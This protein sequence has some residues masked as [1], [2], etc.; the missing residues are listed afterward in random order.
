MRIRHQIPLPSRARGRGRRLGAGVASVT[1]LALGLAACGGGSPATT[2]TPGSSAGTGSTATTQA[3]AS[4]TAVAKPVIIWQPGDEQPFYYANGH[5]LWSR[6]HLQPKEVEVSQGTAELS[7]M[8][9]G[10]A[11]I[12][13]LGPAPFVAG[14]SHGIAMVAV[15]PNV[16]FPTLEGLYVAPNSGITGLRSLPGHSVAVPFGSS[17]DTGL[18]FGLA[19]QGV[20]TARIQFQ[21]DSPNAILAGF[22]RHSIDAAYIWSTWGQRLLGAGARLVSTDA[23]EGVDAGPT[24]LAVRTA[25]LSAH[26]KA[27]AEVIATLDEGSVGTR[28]NPA[29][30][31]GALA[32]ATGDTYQ[33]ALTIAKKEKSLTIADALSPSG[34]DSFVNHST[35][36]AAILAHIALQLKGEGLI[37]TVPKNIG[38][39]VVT[40]PLKAGAKLVAA[41]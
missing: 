30:V 27:V 17:A 8:A 22:V 31:A 24:L 7:A 10:S 20:P 18:R 39:F 5:N 21:N 16:D 9:S 36:V 35:G 6:Y 14:I 11:D 3:T 32:K 26:P 13:L 38:S 37:T 23:S 28:Q 1:A 34:P 41:P 15:M 2:A 33:E 4:G 19:K 12:A 40:G 29:S 25:Y